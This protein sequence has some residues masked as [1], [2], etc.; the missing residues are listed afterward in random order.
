ML[1]ECLR[2]R[3]QTQN[4]CAGSGTSSPLHTILP[5]TDTCEARTGHQGGREQLHD[6]GGC[7]VS[8]WGWGDSYLIEGG[9]VVVGLD[10][11]R[12][13]DPGVTQVVGDR[14]QQANQEVAGG[15]VFGELNDKQR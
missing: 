3:D 15:Q 9:Q 4:I 8:G 13:V 6:P 14:R 2:L 12:L 10:E 5:C 11:E 1:W 7:V